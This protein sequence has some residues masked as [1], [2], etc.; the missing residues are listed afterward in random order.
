MNKKISF[1]K[2]LKN[3][4][5][6]NTSKFVVPRWDSY[7]G[8]QSSHILSLYLSLARKL[9]L[10]LSFILASETLDV[11]VSLKSNIMLTGA[12]ETRLSERE[13]EKIYKVKV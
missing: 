5:E 12:S 13:R 3:F 11:S 7:P 4:V 10:S 1:S 8:L 2:R 6:S 9:S